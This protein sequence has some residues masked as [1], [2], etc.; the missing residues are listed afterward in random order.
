MPYLERMAIDQTCSIELTEDEAL[1]LF[2]FIKRFSDQDQ[3]RIEDLSERRALWNLGSLLEKQLIAP[4]RTEYT[5]L[6]DAARARLRDE[7]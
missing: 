5:S 4:F 3:L 6:L 1:V 2:E 7:D